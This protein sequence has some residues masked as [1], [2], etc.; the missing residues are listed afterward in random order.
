MKVMISKMRKTMDFYINCYNYNET[1]QVYAK[2][3]ILL[4]NYKITHEE[5]I[6]IPIGFNKLWKIITDWK[7]FQKFA[8]SLAESV[9]YDI[10]GSIILKFPKDDNTYYMNILKCD[11]KD[12]YA[13]YE[14]CLN[15]NMP[16]QEL[17]FKIINIDD[18]NCLLKYTNLLYSKN[19]N[20][21]LL[22]KNK[23]DILF[24]LR[25]SLMNIKYEDVILSVL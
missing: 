18:N 5:S 19:N 2:M 14:L 9:E 16:L 20:F 6:I 10:T 12:D 24:Q 23:K 17:H 8:P 7:V 11:K 21:N 25:T 22:I 1:G 3:N 15:S 4:Q 13:V